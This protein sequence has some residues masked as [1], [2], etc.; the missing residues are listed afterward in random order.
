MKILAPIQETCI[1]I[2]FV[3][4]NDISDLES[5]RNQIVKKFI[6]LIKSHF[7]ISSI[8]SFSYN[9]KS[10]LFVWSFSVAVVA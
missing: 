9:M 4:D 5:C 10:R 3:L 2:P 8:T 1:S 6:L 7:V